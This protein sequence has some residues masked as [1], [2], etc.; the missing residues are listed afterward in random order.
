MLSIFI[1]K[2][3]S[4][5]MFQEKVNHIIK[6]HLQSNEHSHPWFPHLTGCPSLSINPPLPLLWLTSCCFYSLTTCDYIEHCHEEAWLAVPQM[7]DFDCTDVKHSDWTC[8]YMGCTAPTLCHWDWSGIKWLL[9]S[10]WCWG[11]E[12]GTVGW[13]LGAKKIT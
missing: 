11:R 3:F 9:C 1:F 7:R 8:E 5:Y 12:L 4:L 10:K 13:S 2:C 6:I